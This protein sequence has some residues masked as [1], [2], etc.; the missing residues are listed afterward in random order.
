M[1]FGR[2]RTIWILGKHNLLSTTIRTN[3]GDV[4]KIIWKM[5]I[6]R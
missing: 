4:Y 3:K 1:L 5:A 6:A 2:L